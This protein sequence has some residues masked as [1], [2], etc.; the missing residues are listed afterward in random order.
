[1]VERDMKCVEERETPN[2]TER[3]S[4]HRDGKKDYDK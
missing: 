3:E 4:I 1:M 2:G